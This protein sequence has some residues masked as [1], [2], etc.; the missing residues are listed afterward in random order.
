MTEG[1]RDYLEQRFDRVYSGYGAS[2]L[3]IGMAGESDLSVVIRRALAHDLDF[4]A[5]VV[6]E[7]RLL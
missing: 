5:G 1:L 6:Q 3:T 2:D 4:R 7:R